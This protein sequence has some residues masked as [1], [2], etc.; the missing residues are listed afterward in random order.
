MQ[1]PYLGGVKP[2]P[3]A[4]APP[5]KILFI[6]N[7]PHETTP[8]VLDG[9]LSQYPGFKEVR[10]IDA[11]PGIAFVEFGNELESTVV[12]QALQGRQMTPPHQILITYAKK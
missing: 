3:E 5:N 4:P 7:L 10:M 11:K 8:V 6:E 9:L 12:M 2:V 1:L